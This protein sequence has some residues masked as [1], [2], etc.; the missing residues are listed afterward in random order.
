MTE[1]DDDNRLRNIF[2]IYLAKVMAN[3]FNQK[4]VIIRPDIIFKR[5]AITVLA[6]FRRIKTAL[7]FATITTHVRGMTNGLSTRMR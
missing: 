5:V 2:I 4:G 6:I 1:V 7:L 3:A